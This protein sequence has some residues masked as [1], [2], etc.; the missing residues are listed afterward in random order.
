MLNIEEGCVVCLIRGAQGA[1]DWLS[2]CCYGSLNC[3]SIGQALNQ[4]QVP[5]V[6]HHLCIIIATDMRQ[7]GRWRT[8]FFVAVVDI[9]SRRRNC[10][11]FSLSPFLCQRMKNLCRVGSGTKQLNASTHAHT[12]IHK[13]TLHQPVNPLPKDDYYMMFG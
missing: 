8:V 3:S 4:I 5:A 2:C 6:C 9:D 10:L 13:F 12:H 11:F 7:G 1:T